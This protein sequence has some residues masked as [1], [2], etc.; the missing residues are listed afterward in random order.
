MK[1]CK[2]HLVLGWLFLALTGCP[3]LTQTPT[4]VTGL[5][6]QSAEQIQALPYDGPKKRVSVMRFDNKAGGQ[7]AWDMGAGMAEQLTTSLVK[8]GRFIVLER[9][10][11]QDIVGEQQFGASGMVKPGTVVKTG[12]IESPEFLVFGA[13]TAF[14]SNY[15]G[16]GVAAGAGQGA[17]IGAVLGGLMAPL[18]GGAAIGSILGG[19]FGAGANYQQAYVSMDVR[20]VDAKSGRVVNATSVT[21]KPQS[22]AANLGL[23]PGDTVFGGSAFYNTPIGQATRECIDK[24]VEWIL[25]T[26]FVEA[27]ASTGT[28]VAPKPAAALQPSTASAPGASIFVVTGQFNFRDGPNGKIL[29]ALK[30]GDQV[31]VLEN[32]GEWSKAQLADGRVVWIITRALKGIDAP[33][34]QPAQVYQQPAPVQQPAAPVAAAPQTAGASSDILY[35]LREGDSLTTVAANLTGSEGN[36]QRIADYN[37]IADPAQIGIGQPIRIPSSILLE[38]FKGK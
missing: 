9:Q 36:W 35:I 5:T 28:T 19:L 1:N 37:R 14:S 4:E 24:A 32:S 10:A 11:L 29:G 18:G 12:Q 34:P 25:K 21:G 16:G 22:A 20:I 26:A 3:A 17:S 6:N 30:S 13:I 7:G 23:A 31:A 15:Q 38:K 2:Y 8:S 33:S 27:V